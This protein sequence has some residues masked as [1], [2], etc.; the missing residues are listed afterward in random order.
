MNDEGFFV[1]PAQVQ[2]L[3]TDL[4]GK[5]NETEMTILLYVHG[6]NHNA[7]DSDPNVACFE[8]LLKATA[9]MQATYKSS[10]H[11]IP[12]GVYGVYVGWPGVVY[13]NRMLN[14]ALEHG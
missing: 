1:E 11:E 13:E 8:E 7:S 9:I 14:T 4:S 3:I 10:D 6:W 5:L 12:R 2:G